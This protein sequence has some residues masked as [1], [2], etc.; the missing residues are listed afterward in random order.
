[1]SRGGSNY[2]E[3]LVNLGKML[4]V[5]VNEEVCKEE[6]TSG[7]GGLDIVGIVDF[8][9]EARGNLA[10]FGQCAARERE[11]PAKTLEAS[12]LRFRA[13]FSFLSDPTNIVFIPLCFR[14]AD[15]TW[16][17][18]SKSS[19]C[20]LLD[21]FRIMSLLEK[22]N[23]FQLLSSTSWFSQFESQLESYS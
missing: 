22:R 14:K 3:A 18:S 23:S 2:R 17:S 16:P 20:V 9:D 19:G 1:M 15:G 5:D 10:L 12:P 6:S 11:W 4:A 8:C 7:D 21:R 13:F